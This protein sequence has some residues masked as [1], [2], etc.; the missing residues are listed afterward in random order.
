METARLLGMAHAIWSGAINFGLVAIPVKLYSVVR[1]H[2]LHFNLLH[3]KD[4]GRI[5]YERVCSACGKNVPW[6]DIVR[7][8]PYSK[9]EYVVVTDEDFAKA[10]VQAT[11]SVDI[12]EFVKLSDID[13][14][15]FDVPYYLA[16]ERRGRHA[17]ALLRTAL[18]KSGKVGIARVVIRTREHLAALK[19][20]GKAL[21]LELMHWADEVVPPSDLELPDE[22]KMQPA[23]MKAATM[24]IDS[25]TTDFHPEELHDTYRERLMQL[26]EARANG[27]RPR[28]VQGKVR[29]PTPVIDLVKVLEKSIAAKGAKKHP[30]KGKARGKQTAA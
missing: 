9:D 14:V 20:S 29:E 5:R 23:E 6:S 30:A 19:P 25:M 2:E 11:Q 12:V 18:E 3:A 28:I 8:F 15:L 16:P 13:P 7:G 10:D 17:Y 26:I 4:N 27:Q 24:L 1:P 22:A 21:A